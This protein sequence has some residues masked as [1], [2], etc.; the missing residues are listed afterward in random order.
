MAEYFRGTLLASPVVRGSSGD[1]YGTH[2]SV[3]GVGGY[4]EVK[5]ITERNSLPINDVSGIDFDGISSGQRRLG[6]LVHVLEEGVIY[7]L[8]PQINNINISLSEWNSLS[9]QDK[10]DELENNDNW[11]ELDLGSAGSNNNISNK[12]SQDDVSFDVGDVVGF[13]GTDFVRVSSLS[14][15]DIEPLGFVTSLTNPTGN[16]YEFRI[17]YAGYIDTSSIIDVDDNPLSQGNVY[18][19]SSDEGKITY[20]EPTDITEVSKPMLIQLEDDRGIVLQYRGFLN[21]DQPVSISEFDKTVTG[22]TNIGY[23][24]GFTGVQTLS[25][26]TTDSDYSGDYNSLYNYYYRD[27][28]GVIRI[29]SPST[30]NDYRRGYVSTDLSST[31]SWVYN[32][33]TG[34]SNQVGWILV[35]GDISDSV[36]DFLSAYQYT[37]TPYDVVEWSY[38]GGSSNDGYYNNGGN[39]TLDVN[40]SLYTGDTYNIGGPIFKTKENKELQFRTIK[41]SDESSIRI[42]HDDN[43]IYLSGSSGTGGTPTYNLNSPS[44]C[45]VGGIPAG[46]NLS[47]YTAFELFQKILAPEMCG[48]LTSPS[49]SMSISPS[50]QLYEIGCE[51]SSL[52]VNGS[53][54]RG[55]IDP[56]YESSSD[57]RVGPATSYEYT[58]DQISGTYTCTDNTISKTLS[59]YVVQQG[60]QEWGVTVNYE[61]GVQPLGSE[62]TP[63]DDACPSGSLSDT[64][65]IIGTYP[66]YGTTSSI[67]SLAKQSLVNMATANNIQMELVSEEGGNKQKFDIPDEW[68]DSRPLQGVCQYN[69][70]SS[71]WEYP[72]GSQSA[73]LNIW[74]TS[75]TT[76]TIQGNV[77]DYN[78]YTYNGV[79][80][81]SVCIRLVF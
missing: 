52:D 25:I 29:G 9:E 60:S 64:S 22:A 41:S 12:F 13:D 47:G 78:R 14:A 50:T 67:T 15:G 23:F 42:T 57:K 27:D 62:G 40:G 8:L 38:T 20:I 31:K 48:T 80:R 68:L 53:F 58:G 37:G 77:V 70:V 2:H 10:L 7:R 39:L 51:I 45:T 17:V 26:S 3:L 4:I 46:T 81:G 66:I 18:Y 79:D 36:G 16:T 24:S 72:G 71:Q 6:M 59:N 54:N 65:S 69:T 55:C 74:S 21:S 56:Q 73:S 5:T 28:S 32:T 43:Y 34:D 11:H 35:D 30:V 75:S 49:F 1:T 63:Y 19:L 33:Y 61:E 44:T 76:H